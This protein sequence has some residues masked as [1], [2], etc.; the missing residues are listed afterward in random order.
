LWEGKLAAP[1]NL[2]VLGSGSSG[3]DTKLDAKLD[4]ESHAEL[5]TRVWTLEISH[6]RVLE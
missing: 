5:C 6:V 4:A 1:K 3:V 2:P